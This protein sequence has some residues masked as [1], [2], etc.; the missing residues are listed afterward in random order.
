LEKKIK[1]KEAKISIHKNQEL[2]MIQEQ[3][4]K[5]QKGKTILTLKITKLN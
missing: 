3:L 5:A 1:E 4:Q 2:Q